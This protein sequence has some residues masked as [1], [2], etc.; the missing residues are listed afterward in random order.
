M[1]DHAEPRARHR[2]RPLRLHRALRLG[3][4]RAGRVPAGADGRRER[5]RRRSRPPRRALPVPQRHPAHRLAGRGST[6]MCPDGGT[7]AVLGPRPGR[8]VRG[9]HRRA[10]RVSRDRA[11]TRSPSDERWPNGTA[12]RSSTSTTT[13]LD[14]SA[15]R[16]RRRAAPTA[17]VDAVGLEAHGNPGIEFVQKAVGLLP[18]AVAKPLMQNGRRRSPRR[19]ARSPST[20]VRRGGTVSLSGVYARRRGPDADDDDV[21]QAAHAAH[22]PV[23]RARVAR[24]AAAARRGSGRPARRRGSR[25]PPVPLDRAPEMYETFQKKQDGCIKVVLQPGA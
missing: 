9:A 20:L 12:S 6:R 7:L 16:D 8:A 4:G 2:R 15:R 10:P 11:S 17:V 5:P 22:G 25:D 14:G 24:R 21:R 1:R 13:P 23:Q 19:A 18:D 3:A